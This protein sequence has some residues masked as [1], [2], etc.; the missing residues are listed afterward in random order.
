MLKHTAR[1]RAA[2][3]LAPLVWLVAGLAL[4]ASSLQ[5][6]ASS[7]VPRDPH[8]IPALNVCE[9]VGPAFVH[10]GCRYTT[11]DPNA[12]LKALVQAYWKMDEFSDGSGA[13]TRADSGPNGL[14][15]TDNNTVA[16]GTGHVYTNA[17]DVE[18]DNSEYFSRA[19]S[20]PIQ[21]GDVD[22]TLMQWVKFETINVGLGVALFGKENVAGTQIE[23]EGYIN[24]AGLQPKLFVAT[25]SGAAGTELVSSPAAV[26]GLWELWFFWHDN[27]AN[28]INIQKNNGV[29][30]ST[31]LTVT[32][33]TNAHGFAFGRLG[34]RVGVY[35]AFDALLGPGAKFSAVLTSDQRLR[36]FNGGAGLALYP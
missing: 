6:Q 19:S 31:A 32:P 14:H 26:A 17:A 34:E 15:L 2:V 22:W 30:T 35:V 16:S 23:V 25:G 7:S 12:D 24:A 29:P 13:V 33:G 11:A 10:A 3:L 18:T 21:F 1:K 4:L 8:P 27:A 28:T 36:L 20:A 9:A 5:G